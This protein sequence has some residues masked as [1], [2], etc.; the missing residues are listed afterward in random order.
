MKYNPNIPLE[1]YNNMGEREWERLDKDRENELL[2]HVHYDILKRHILNNDNVIE[3][4]AGGGIFT[5]DIVQMCNSLVTSDI[6]P[7][8]VEV[9]KKMM[10]KLG[11]FEKIK[12]FLELDISNLELIDDNTF[13]IAVCTGGSINYLFDKEDCAIKEMLR[14][15]K[16][17]GKLI[18]GAMSLTG[19]LIYHLNGVIYEKGLFGIDASRWIFETGMQDGEHYPV[20]NKHYVHMMTSNDMDKLFENKQVKILEKSS[21]GLFTHSREAALSNAKSDREFWD[22]LIQK[23]IA[24][25]KMAGTL[26]SGMNIIYVVEKL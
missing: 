12:D 18:L 2:Y 26:D 16:S 5:K 23:E 19:S 1:K 14:V 17:G 22:L 24:F 25:T 13:D 9:N 6:S 11:L 7:V 15:L 10:K 20:E 8:Q 3:F 4:G 21:A